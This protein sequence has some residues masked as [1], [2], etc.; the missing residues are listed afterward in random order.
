VDRILS[1]ALAGEPHVVLNVKASELLADAVP[2]ASAINAVLERA[3]PGIMGHLL[4]A[5]A[6]RPSGLDSELLNSLVDADPKVRIAA[7][8]LC[9]ALR[10]TDSLPWLADLIQDPKPGGGEGAV[11]ALGGPGGRRRRRSL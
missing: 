7:A 6:L 5:Q 9:G 2:V 3:G 1:A 11:C 10:M 4:V 8:R